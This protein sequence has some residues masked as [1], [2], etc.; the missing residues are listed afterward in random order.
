MRAGRLRHRVTI[1]SI[2]E[3]ADT[4]G[5]IAGTPTNGDIV[6]ASV[7]PLVGREFM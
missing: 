2:T 5:D 1:Q 4:Y 6:W 7:E 3:A